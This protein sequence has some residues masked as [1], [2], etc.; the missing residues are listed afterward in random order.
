[1]GQK[2]RIQVVILDSPSLFSSFSILLFASLSWDSAAIRA[3]HSTVWSNVQARPHASFMSHN[4]R[5]DEAVSFLVRL[6]SLALQNTK[7]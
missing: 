6:I 7:R 4:S 5:S 2:S 1:M 3:T